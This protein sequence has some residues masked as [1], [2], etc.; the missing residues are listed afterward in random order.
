M[1]QVAGHWNKVGRLPSQGAGS[2]GY[3]GRAESGPQIKEREVGAGGRASGV[4]GRSN[5][6]QKFPARPIGSKLSYSAW[7]QICLNQA[8]PWADLKVEHLL[9]GSLSKAWEHWEARAGV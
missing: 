4:R 6:S 5:H 2:V 3:Q 7:S 1:F 9:L 8:G